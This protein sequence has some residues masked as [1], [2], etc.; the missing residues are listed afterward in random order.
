MEF[1]EVIEA[2][3][4]NLRAVASTETETPAVLTKRDI[5]AGIPMTNRLD[6][7]TLDQARFA[8]QN[9]DAWFSYLKAN[10][11]EIDQST[12]ASSV[13]IT[14]A[15]QFKAICDT[16]ENVRLVFT[17]NMARADLGREQIVEWVAMLQWTLPVLPTEYEHQRRH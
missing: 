5:P 3:Q 1:S 12:G 17:G 6:K 7:L 16:L 4:I 8:I 13:E 15:E 14:P 10:G 9:G 11:G 2:Q